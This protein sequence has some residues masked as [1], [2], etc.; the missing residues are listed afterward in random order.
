ME[1]K[2]TLE[3]LIE[4]NLSEE[5]L[6]KKIVLALY[7]IETWYSKFDWTD[8][9]LRVVDYQEIILKNLCPFCKSNLED[10]MVD[11]DGTNLIEMRVC[12]HCQYKTA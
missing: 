2:I 6:D 3:A 1:Y 11:I 9:N 4:S 10:R 5:E 8:D 7:D 12:L